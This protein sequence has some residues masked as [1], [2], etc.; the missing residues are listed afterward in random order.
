ME[1]WP[2]VPTKALRK[3]V[4]SIILEFNIQ[5]SVADNPDLKIAIATFEVSTPKASYRIIRFQET[6]D[7]S[8]QT[9]GYAI[10]NFLRDRGYV[11]VDAEGGSLWA[12]QCRPERER[13]FRSLLN[14]ARA[15]LHDIREQINI[16]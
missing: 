1:N 6:N 12:S 13:E 8:P 5:Q 4:D 14:Q 16:D 9:H 10:R 11:P 15:F 2:Y 7:H 3:P